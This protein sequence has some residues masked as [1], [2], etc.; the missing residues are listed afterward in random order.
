[1]LHEGFKV[2]MFGPQ[3]CLTSS[4]EPPWNTPKLVGC[5]HSS[6]IPDLNLE[7]FS[8]VRVPPQIKN[9]NTKIRSSWE[10][11]ILY[12]KFCHQTLLIMLLSCLQYVQLR[13]LVG[14]SHTVLI[15]QS[16]KKRFQYIL[17]ESIRIQG[18]VEE[19][20]TNYLPSTCSTPQINPY[21]VWWHLVSLSMV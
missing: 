8:S 7:G 14:N 19:Y 21:V 11:T 1:M 20:W 9:T 3:T 13:H 18:F 6:H 12:W 4:K 2:I 15:S 10:A 16:F 5:N 17:N